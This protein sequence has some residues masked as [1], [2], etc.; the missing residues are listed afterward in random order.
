MFPRGDPSEGKRASGRRSVT[1]G[2]GARRSEAEG[3]DGKRSEAKRGEA[4]Q[5]EAKREHPGPSGGDPCSSG[6]TILGTEQWV[7]VNTGIG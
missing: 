4:M 2:G 7:T 5:G 3:S 1:E 6:S